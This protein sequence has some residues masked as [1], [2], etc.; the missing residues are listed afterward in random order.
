MMRVG[1]GSRSIFREECK[2]GLEASQN[3]FPQRQLSLPPRSADAS[4]VDTKGEGVRT[5]SLGHRAE[6]VQGDA[7]P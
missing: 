2:R 1:V 3:L 7:S 6:P 5:F 4:T